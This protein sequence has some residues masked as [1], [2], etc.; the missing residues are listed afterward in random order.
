MGMLL[1]ASVLLYRYRM[2][3]LMENLIYSVLLLACFL[4]FTSAE[5][6]ESRDEKLISTFQIVR[7]PNDACVGSNSRNGTCYTSA[8]CSDKAGTSSGSCAD[9]FGVCCTF[10][11]ATCGSSSSENNT[12]W[13]QPTS[14]TGPSSCDLT[15][16]PASDNIC[17]L[18]LDFTTF[19]IT[20]P[21]TVTND[22]VLRHNGQ[23]VSMYTNKGRA[24]SGNSFRTNCLVDTFSVTGPSASSTPPTIC[25]TNTGMHMY[26]DVTP[27]ECNRMMFTLGEVAS[28]VYVTST[29]GVATAT[30]ARTWDMTVQQI[31][32]TS[33]T[34]PP[35]GCTEYFWGSG[36]GFT[37]KSY[38]YLGSTTA[39]H[40]ANQHQRQCI[41]R[42]RGNCI[43][44]FV[45]LAAADMDISGGTA[46]VKHYTQVG[47]CCGYAG[48]A[49]GKGNLLA[50]TATTLAIAG[51]RGFAKHTNIATTALGQ[52]GW[53]CIIIPGAFGPTNLHTT[54]SLVLN[55]AIAGA[56][57]SQTTANIQQ[58]LIGSPT[59]SVGP[60]PWP[61]QICGFG[62][63][64]GIGDTYI[65]TS[66]NGLST[67]GSNTNHSICTKMVPFTLEFMSDDLEGLGTTATYTEHST[68]VHNTGYTLL[69]EQIACA[70]SS[71][72]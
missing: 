63:G 10:V 7:F 45:A 36:S 39:G 31:E 35:S 1:R 46:D 59:A 15:V 56:V 43:G 34:L 52:Y 40:L 4:H 72:G 16:C 12:Y 19:A 13:T 54:T 9:G 3:Q 33:L 49:D 57:S 24:V 22:Q 20:G 23:P 11:I 64:I 27:T 68:A 30:T 5:D 38:N 67:A 32:C 25:G 53:D 17:R 29:R 6:T 37:L 58:T 21:S 62:A 65:H 66:V 47:G 61:P 70:T 48:P 42:E 28:S 2:M 14:T 69:H 41:R 71:T 44:C 60:T 55:I 8:E 50:I 26:V 18:R 51:L